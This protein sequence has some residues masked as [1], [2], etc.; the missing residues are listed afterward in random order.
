MDGETSLS[1]VSTEAQIALAAGRPLLS[2]EQTNRLLRQHGLGR[3]LATAMV[4]DS[5]AATVPLTAEEEH[6]LIR[7][8]L[9]PEGVNGDDAL[10]AWLDRQ[11]WSFDDL[12][13]WATLPERLRRWQ[14]WR[15]A[16]EVEI[17]FLERKADLDQVSYSLLRVSDA[18]LAEELYFRIKEDG[19]DFSELVQEF[20]E[21]SEKASR[22]LI[23]P[24]A[25]SAG[26]PELARRLRISSPGQLW[27]PFE[28]AGTWLLIRLEQHWPVQL[29]DDMSARMV[30]ELFELWVNERVQRLLDGED[31]PPLPQPPLA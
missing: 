3:A 27:P 21:G 20:S 18:D 1:G 23:G 6:P 31:L 10:L 7:A 5:V 26:H 12:R 25:V 19:V 13:Q 17:H 30:S 22:G 11:R 15:F 29:D 8:A 28:V 2:V 9:E 16:A 4:H 14:T 24:V